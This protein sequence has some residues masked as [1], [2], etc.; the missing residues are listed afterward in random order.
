LS[1]EQPLTVVFP[2]DS[3]FSH[4]IDDLDPRLLLYLPDSYRPTITLPS[5]R[6]IPPTGAGCEM[7][8]SICGEG[9]QMVLTG[10]R[11]PVCYHCLSRWL[12]YGHLCPYCRQNIQ[13]SR[14]ARY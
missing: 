1:P 14:L 11:H 9:E 12:Q 7:D 5:Y 10:C 3:L 4:P 6:E 8:C 2:A 13:T